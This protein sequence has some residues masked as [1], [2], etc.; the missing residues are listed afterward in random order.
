MKEIKTKGAKISNDDDILILKYP[1]GTSIHIDHIL[2]TAKGFIPSARIKALNMQPSNM[3]YNHFHAICG[4]QYDKYAKETAKKLRINLTG[5]PE[6]CIH[7]A[8]G[9]IKKTKISK[10]VTNNEEF[11]EERIE[12]DIMGYK[13]VS[14]G[15]I[16]MYM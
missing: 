13:R 8:R 1:D 9:K 6:D 10:E 5:S 7:C 4:H 11:H 16:S 12:M 15:E 14:K 2:S 3:K